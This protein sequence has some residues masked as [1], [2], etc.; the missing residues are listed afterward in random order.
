MFKFP[1]KKDRVTKPLLHTILIFPICSTYILNNMIY[2]INFNVSLYENLD[3]K[4]KKN[5]KKLDK[6][7]F[8]LMVGNL[9]W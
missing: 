3:I 5:K 1:S 9:E 4:I 7:S 6:W 8:T 2:D